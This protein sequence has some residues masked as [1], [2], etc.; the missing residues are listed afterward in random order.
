MS[1][2]YVIKSPDKT[3]K[4]GVSEDTNARITQLQTGNGNKLKLIYESNDFINAH[5]VEKAIHKKLESKRTIGEWFLYSYET[6][7]DVV[8]YIEEYGETPCLKEKYKEQKTNRCI[9]DGFIYVSMIETLLIK[10]ENEDIEQLVHDIYTGSRN[11]ELSKTILNVHG[12]DKFKSLCKII[13]GL[14][15]CGWDYDRVKLFIEQTN[16]KQLAG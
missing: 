9:L 7:L 16:T 11:S 10:R 15:D 3:M 2:V 4:I 6:F 1:K 12:E 14:F 8:R 13:S 5:E